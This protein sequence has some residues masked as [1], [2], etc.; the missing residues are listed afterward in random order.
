MFARIPRIRC[1]DRKYALTASEGHL[2]QRNRDYYEKYTRAEAEKLKALYQNM[3][4]KVSDYDITNSKKTLLTNFRPRGYKIEKQ[5][6]PLKKPS[7][8]PLTPCEL[9]KIS[10]SPFMIQLEGIVPESYA[11]TTIIM[12][13]NNEFSVRIYINPRRKGVVQ[14]P[15][16]D[17]KVIKANAEE[18][19][20]IIYKAENIGK[21]YVA[22]D[23]V[24]NE[25]HAYECILQ[26][27]V[28]PGIVTTDVKTIEFLSNGAPRKYIKL[29]NPCNAAVTFSWE[30]NTQSLSILPQ[31]GTVPARS[32]MYSKILYIPVISEQLASEII[33]FSDRKSKV[34]IDVFA[35]LVKPKVGLSTDHLEIP[36]VPLNI[37]VKRRIILR[38][39]GNEN[40]LF[41]VVNATPIPG[42]TVTPPE[43][44][45]RGCGD[46]I[47]SVSICIPACIT[48]SCIVQI[49]VQKLERIQFKI[50]GTV[51]YPQIV[52]KPNSLNLR[53]VYL[54]CFDK[55][56][57]QI[58][59]K[60]KC[61][62]SIKFN[63]EYYPEFYVS[64]MPL[65]GSPAINNKE[66]LVL[67]PDEQKVLYLHFFPIDVA[68]NCFY[69]PIIVNNILG[70]SSKIRI[71]TLLTNTFLGPGANLYKP[72]FATVTEYPIK[73]HCTEISNIVSCAILEFSE[74]KFEFYKYTHLQFK[75]VTSLNFSI[76]NVSQA[77]VSLSIHPT[78]SSPFSI[79]HLEGGDI[80]YGKKNIMTITLSSQDEI[81]LNVVFSPINL[82]EYTAYFPIYL[83]G[84]E[85]E[86][87]NYIVMHGKLYTPR[88]EVPNSVVY[89]LP[90]PLGVLC[91]SHFTA[92]L[93]YHN[94]T[95]VFSNK[96]STPE[97]LISAYREKQVYVENRF[98]DLEKLHVCVFHTASV[99]VEYVGTVI[100]EC[101]CGASTTFTVRGAVDHCILTTHIFRN[102]YCAREVEHSDSILTGLS[103]Q[104][105]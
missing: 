75:S 26:A 65:K 2:R 18:H 93:H 20:G 57:F 29:T 30:N 61:V 63:F 38:N 37:P 83:D 46:Q 53:K 59:N 16:G 99:A 17:R 98:D 92:D 81:I 74:L 55:F 36:L 51:E 42:I 102:V 21:H 88:I 67:K 19:I 94:R 10:V 52:V 40:V 91:E 54:G 56:K 71:D 27:R 68:P 89:M 28:I 49:E 86:P 34:L 73:L 15:E 96:S 97:L 50:S 6:V 1:L 64:T 62:A 90:V 103:V 58:A 87:Y 85:D 5:T 69:L 100:L 72:E 9:N 66:G 105:V 35:T 39:F 22:M 77:V 24:V 70:P 32:S 79:N 60:G 76:K 48:F 101:S 4:K 95:C 45:L 13:N 104:T 47:F 12:K 7:F 31:K 84:M 25:S 41:K 23:I 3:C 8:T 44:I 82:E 43:G 14:F 11:N 78:D 80:L 33:L